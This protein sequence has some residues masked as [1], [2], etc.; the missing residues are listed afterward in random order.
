MYTKHE[1]K[2]WQLVTYVNRPLGWINVL[3][4]RVNNYYP[5]EMRILKDN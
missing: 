2:G 1:N 4:N 5:K 3:P